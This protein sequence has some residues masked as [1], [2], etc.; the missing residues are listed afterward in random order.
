MKVNKLKE[1]INRNQPVFGM[2]VS[3]PHPIMIE[4]IGYAE[5]DFV[6]IDYEH[7][8]TN[9]ETIE[10]MVRAAE[11]VNITPLVRISKVDRN[12]ILKVLDCGAQGIVIPHVQHKKQVEKAVHYAYYHPIG[13]RSLNSG[14]PGVFAKYSLNDYIAKANEEI[15]VVP[16]IESLEGIHESESILSSPYVSFVLEGA[17]DLS[18]SLSVPWETDHPEVQRH[19]EELYEVS[20]RCKVPY[21]IVSRNHHNHKKWAEKGTKIFV[22]GDERGTAFRAYMEKLA[23]Y[24]NLT[25]GLYES[26]YKENNT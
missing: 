13:M 22:L 3:I 25:G 19:L 26:L 5:F 11:L 20:K 14:R 4:L 12:E 17:V 24:Q 1:K 8:S 21:A 15:M 18:Q 10:E 7:A 6:I 23:D 9:M 16:M 2:F